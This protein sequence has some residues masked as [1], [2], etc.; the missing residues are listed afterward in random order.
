MLNFLFGFCMMMWLLSI[1]RSFLRFH[2][3]EKAMANNDW[4]FSKMRQLATA[5]NVDPSTIILDQH[6]FNAL[7][8]QAY[9]GIRESERLIDEARVESTKSF[10]FLAIALVVLLLLIFT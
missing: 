9:A 5:E 2:A 4:V 3:A 1:V 10:F 7:K 6:T 8:D